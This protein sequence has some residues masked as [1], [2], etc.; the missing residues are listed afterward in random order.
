YI[1]RGDC[2]A[3]PPS[4]IGRAKLPCSCQSVAA[5]TVGAA[6]HLDQLGD[7]GPLVLGIAAG[8]R[9]LDAMADM[10]LQHD[11]LDPAQGGADRGDLR[12]HVDA[13]AI[14][15]H[16]AREAAHL[17]FDPGE[18]LQAVLLGVLLH[19]LT[20]T[21][22]GYKSQALIT[23]WGLTAENAMRDVVQSHHRGH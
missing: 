4:L 15:L 9:M 14:A 18:T 1:V 8:D 21:P 11:L 13:I 20:Y 17:A 22:M 16:H 2:S 19:G 12:H 7:L 6:E 5:S 10:I 23:P 3:K